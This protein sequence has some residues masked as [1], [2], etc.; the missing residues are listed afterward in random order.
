VIEDMVTGTKFRA[1]SSDAKK[2]HGMSPSV[3]ILDEL[4][5]WGQGLGRELYTALTTST[6]ARGEP[7]TLVISTQTADDHALMSQL[8]EYGKQV[9]AGTVT[10]PTF[11]AF[12]YEV[13]LEADPWDETQ[14]PL[15]N[16]ALGDFRSRA[17]MQN[18]AERA[19]QMPTDAAM[20]RL[21]YL[22]Q[23]VPDAARWIPLDAWD[24][25]QAPW[26][27]ARRRVFLG[28]DLSTRRDLTALALLWPDD[29]GGF[30]V[31]VEFWCPADGIAIRSQK[32]RVPYAQWVQE[33]HLTATGGNVVDYTVVEARIHALMREYDVVEVAVDPWNAR[34]VTARLVT[35]GVPAVEVAQTLGNLT[36]ASKAFERLILSQQLR[37]D[38]HPVLRWCVGN[39]VADV[40]GNGNLKPSKD[41]SREKIDGVSALVT[42]LARALV[43]QTGSVYDQ[44]GVVTIPA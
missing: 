41:R 30:D 28:V 26:Q 10:D 40:D 36:T 43:T 33:G 27:S 4:A 9:N 8:V 14:W 12:I 11:S 22:N 13:P 37:H 20:F 18:F 35:D 38:G 44:R 34:D 25:C 3:I 19:K 24:A 1:L 7:L 29:T 15:A 17:E 42:A 39:A 16:P 23:R 2:A 21:Y 5:Q 32:D 31:A 6:G